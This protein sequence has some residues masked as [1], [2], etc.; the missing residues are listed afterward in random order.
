MEIVRYDVVEDGMRPGMAALYH[1]EIHT[2]V[3]YHDPIAAGE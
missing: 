2:T 1:Q 3:K